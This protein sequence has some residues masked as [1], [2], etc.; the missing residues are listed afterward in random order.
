MRSSRI[1]LYRRALGVALLV[2]TP[3]HIAFQVM[4]GLGS[5]MALT[6]RPELCRQDA[7]VG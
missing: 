5:F 3:A 4:A 7:V 2:G 6:A 1:V